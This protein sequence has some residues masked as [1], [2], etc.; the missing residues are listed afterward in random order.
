M[1]SSIRLSTDLIEER[2]RNDYWREVT[3]P[4]FETIID[5]REAP[6]TLYG[7]ITANQIGELVMGETKF[8]A[9]KYIR[10][11]HSISRFGLDHYMIQVVTQGTQ[12]GDFN[13]ICS[14]AFVGDILI[15]DMAY[16]LTTEVTP[17]SRM[18]MVLPR[19]LVQRSGLNGN[20][21]GRVLGSEDPLTAFLVN[22]TQGFMKV[23]PHLN[24]VQIEGIQNSIIDMFAMSLNGKEFNAA[25][26][27]TLSIITKQRI[28]DY[29]DRNIENLS[30]ST[31]SILKRFNISRSHLYRI[32]AEEGG[33]AAIIRNKRLT[34]AFRRLRASNGRR[35]HLAELA[36]QSGFSDYSSF[37]KL[38][39][40]KYGE[41]PTDIRSKIQQSVYQEIG[42]DGKIITYFK[43]LHKFHYAEESETSSEASL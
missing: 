38:F 35:I 42:Y 23:S 2:D 16:K 28:L 8:N 43:N 34:L 18:T 36:Y 29:I 32:F 7:E 24:T 5:P 17:G 40:E 37:S 21:H 20:I 15:M 22:C 31:G 9:Q 13:G 3:L 10:D 6:Q 25:E 41:K 30:L 39:H 12:R 1:I 11:E 4:A 14:Q 26:S 27:T 33:I 19:A